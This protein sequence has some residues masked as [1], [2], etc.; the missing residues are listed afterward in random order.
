MPTRCFSSRYARGWRIHAKSRVYT[1]NGTDT[2][3]YEYALSLFPGMGICIRIRHSMLSMFFSTFGNIRYAILCLG[4]RRQDTVSRF[5]G[6][7]R[8]AHATT[9]SPYWN[10]RIDEQPS[11]LLAVVIL[12]IYAHPQVSAWRGRRP[13]GLWPFFRRGRLAAG[14]PGDSPAVVTARLAAD[15]APSRLREKR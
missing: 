8:K 10:A 9:R 3:I 12:K 4:Q 13:L 15:P 11:P 2:F 1:R 7:D 6:C 14:R 5:S